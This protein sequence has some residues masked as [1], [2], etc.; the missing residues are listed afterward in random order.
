MTSRAGER[1]PSIGVDIMDGRH[2]RKCRKL[3]LILLATGMIGC[4]IKTAVEDLPRAD[5]TLA[6]AGKRL[7]QTL[8]ASD[9]TIL[10][11]MEI[12]YSPQ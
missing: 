7:I 4:S 2:G 6:A 5:E 8:P 10:A 11:T 1:D 12:R 3:G 9:L